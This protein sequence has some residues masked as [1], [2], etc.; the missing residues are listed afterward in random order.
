MASSSSSQSQSQSPA[1]RSRLSNLLS[2]IPT[3]STLSL[4]Q[5]VAVNDALLSSSGLLSSSACACS[6]ADGSNDEARGVAAA[7]LTT[8]DAVRMLLIGG[9]NEEDD[10]RDA[11]VCLAAL[12]GSTTY[13][14]AADGIGDESG[15]VGD[16][17]EDCERMRGARALMASQYLLRLA[18]AGATSSD[19][20][21]NK[22]D[23][24]SESSAIL[25]GLRRAVLPLLLRPPPSDAC[26]AADASPMMDRNVR[27][28][29]IEAAFASS[30]S[31]KEI[32]S[33]N[34]GD[35]DTES[36]NTQLERC[37]KDCIISVQASLDALT[38]SDSTTSTT[39][40]KSDVI[41]GRRMMVETSAKL[42]EGMLSLA[43]NHDLDD[44][45]VLQAMHRM[46]LEVAA[47]ICQ[48]GD[49][50]L[51]RPLTGLLLPILWDEEHVPSAAAKEK[52]EAR[53]LELW[54]F[55]EGIITP[56]GQ[57]DGD[58]PDT[59]GKRCRNW[60]DA[61]PMIATG[62]LCSSIQGLAAYNLSSSPLSGS[63]TTDGK[64]PLSHS[65]FLWEFI[66]TTLQRM[67]DG[68]QGGMKTGGSFASTGLA[69]DADAAAIDQI[70]RRRA[71]HILRL[72]VEYEEKNRMSASAAGRELVLTWKKYVLC[73]EALEMENE[74]HL[75]E[76]VWPT[77]TELCDACSK[78]EVLLSSTSASHCDGV[79]PMSWDWIGSLLARVFQSD[80]PTLK[81]LAIYRFLVGDAGVSASAAKVDPSAAVQAPSAPEEQP[82]MESAKSKKEKKRKDKVKKKKK[83]GGAKKKTVHPA[84]LS[85]VSPLFI[86]A[87]L[88]PSFDS[89]FAS[90]GT[91]INIDVNGKT[92]TDELIPRLQQ[93]IIDYMR[94]L[95]A[96]KPDFISDFLTGVM[97]SEFI[98]SCRHRTLALLYEAVG[99]A[100]EEADES[101][102]LPLSRVV[103][104]ETALS[105]KENF[106]TGGVLHKV[107]ASILASFAKILANSTSADHANPQLVLNVLELYSSPISSADDEK[108]DENPCSKNDASYYKDISV[109]N[110]QCWI[111]GLGDETEWAAEAGA[112]C[113]SAYIAGHLLP[114]HDARANSGR[115]Y[116]GKTEREMG[117]SIVKLCTLAGAASK[118]K[119]ASELL[120][121]AINKGLQPAVPFL[122]ADTTS[123]SQQLP[124][125]IEVKGK[126]ARA[127]VLLDHGCIERIVNG[128][129]NGDLVVANKSGSMLP[130]PNEIENL[131][132]IVVSVILSQI[133]LI[134]SCKGEAD[135]EQTQAGDAGIASGPRVA[136]R[137]RA[138]G[139]LSS[140][141]ARWCDCLKT[142][143]DAFPSSIVLESTACDLLCKSLDD[144]MDPSTLEK[145]EVSARGQMRMC[146]LMALVF[147]ALACGG[148]YSSHSDASRN[149][150]GVR[151]A[152]I[153][154][155]EFILGTT[156][157]IPEGD[158]G[159]GLTKM[160]MKAARSL[161]QYAKWGAL[162]YLIPMTHVE[163]RGDSSELRAFYRTVFK[164][165][166]DVIHA[167]PENALLPLF[168]AVLSAAR[169]SVGSDIL[170]DKSE[171][172]LSYSKYIHSI[173]DSLFGVLSET[174]H[175]PTRVYMIN[176][177]C[178][179]L[180]RPRLLMN[181]YIM[182]QESGI[183]DDGS[184][185]TWP[186]RKAFH[187]LLKLS[188]R[189]PHI[190]KAA[191]SY[192]SAA[193][194]GT[195][196]EDGR[197]TMG[198]SAIP[199]RK[200]IARL[201]V[202]KEEKI[203][204]AAS[205]Q[206]IAIKSPGANGGIIVEA[207]ALSIP[208]T[209][210]ELSI[211]RGFLLTFIS[212]LPDP[213]DGLDTTVL[214]QLCHHIILN[215]LDTM[216]AEDPKSASS[217]FITGS[218]EY[219]TKIRAWQALCILHRFVTVEI[220]QEVAEKVYKT[221]DQNLHGQIRYFQEV[222]AIQC[223]RKHPRIF[224]KKFVSE[225]RRCDL[226]QQHVSSLMILGGNLI[227][228]RY[229]KEVFEAFSEE[230]V[231]DPLNEILAGTL[232][233]LSSTQGFAR[234]IAQLLVH[235][236]TPLVVERNGEVGNT[237]WYLDTMY[238]FLDQNSDMARLRKKQSKFFD[239][240]D[241]DP[242]CTP[243]GML[244][245][246]V[247]V[248]DEADPVH[249]VSAI[250]K[251]LEE[252]YEEAHE[253]DAPQ[254]KQV[255]K[256]L[257]DIDE[258]ADEDEDDDSD[259][260]LI[261]FQRKIVPLDSLNLSLEE[262]HE[263]SIRNAAGRKRQE[264]IVC[265][266]FVDKIPNLGGLARTAEIFA[267]NRLVIPDKRVVKMDNFKSISVS[268]G[269]W[270]EIEEVKE[271]D[272]WKWLKEKK[273]EH[274]TIVG[275][276]QTSSS[277]CLSRHKF[278]SKTV[279]LLGKEKEG[280]P[281]EYLQLVDTCLEIPQL[282][283]I[284]SLN[285]HVT[286]AISI[287]E[288]TKQHLD[289]N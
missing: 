195:D 44:E 257:K 260:A 220:A 3:D 8:E 276:E 1:A 117:C 272:L 270:I 228:G 161:F 115:L 17:E 28:A 172:L 233:W 54:T 209:T 98:S 267:A 203:D 190:A 179:L 248:G 125:P 165:G 274:Y 105:L 226:S 72:L 34:D 253:A 143:C 182:N 59:E 166:V 256:A 66:K 234:A 85:I 229:S 239:S 130:P 144:L 131:L 157:V 177:A 128:L 231:K 14:A 240:Y 217:S 200:D 100:A 279:L 16:G 266:T 56:S 251:C 77:T 149:G 91:N 176:S 170:S 283:I 62:I 235:K 12:A 112:A 24:S 215:L 42:L 50:R 192:I 191:V 193:W 254:W 158:L 60:K 104:E 197:K 218:P 171:G 89:L 120:W 93:F 25:N 97:S 153:E 151:K 148:D 199:Y 35:R 7:A 238:N 278:S 202:F 110:L 152:P 139:E 169:L 22:A 189:K 20:G 88:L 232:P 108:D 261:G 113:A 21:S 205:F 183:L 255:K 236:I 185:D 27:D 265:A 207:N 285:V 244:R 230:E 46:V 288:Y 210:S 58:S 237:N 245:I 70:L 81:K 250:K 51:L 246:P 174:P 31:G 19:S 52:K 132:A 32:S 286:G 69:A 225:V 284:R 79:P 196:T 129:G 124:M 273:D 164:Q 243:E 64:I 36:I 141:L 178:A 247:D 262:S 18:T 41:L 198:I 184:N 134:V 74:V 241:A 38:G 95:R 140:A 136:T 219:C 68:Q 187:T 204:D 280:I 99:N 6:E 126:V 118:S 33:K 45:I 119:S 47:S 57:G 213:K 216:L 86:T 71:I 146:N 271:T 133:R 13:S 159:E 186:V 75:V 289:N 180:F 30:T 145:P 29:I 142:L 268:A 9:G 55:I 43:R 263:Q 135:L 221:M 80:S 227:V 94:I 63:T 65:T 121:P 264:L 109:A 163:G 275:L 127:I 123:I 92:V 150:E 106:S 87:V 90:V 222:F 223:H 26:D 212:K 101:S 53:A 168:E 194:L 102:K 2:L 167:T 252:V 173:V 15:I 277:T 73:F 154:V 107:R 103:I 201:L 78:S 39:N 116:V 249:M 82:A 10:C 162:S 155:C 287:W 4:S 49:L 175:G 96:D 48:S 11:D 84:R 137:S 23:A 61:A 258:V 37:A 5:L 208:S 138:T 206:N 111:G 242:V 224:I 269:D 281:V 259:E 282:G 67:G 214:T 83:G 188:V 114:F 147:A 181:E 156:F 211:V 40:N 76:Q 122:S 160:Q